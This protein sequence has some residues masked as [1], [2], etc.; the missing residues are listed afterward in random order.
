VPLKSYALL[1]G[2]PIAHQRETTGLTPHHQVHV[3]DD[4]GVDYRVPINVRSKGTTPDVLYLVDDDFQHPVT[5]AI[6]ALGPGRHALGPGPGGPNLDFVRAN[7]FDATQMRVLP[8]NVDGPE[9]D[10]QDILEGWLDRAIADP[11]ASIHVLGEPWGPE[12]DPDEKFGFSPGNGVHDIHMNQGNDEEFVDQDGVWQDGGLLFHFPGAGRWVAIFLSF[13]SQKWHTDD[14][15][16]HAL[17][18]EVPASI[19]IVAALVNPIGPAPEQERVLLLNASP[20][21][22][23]LTGWRLADRAKQTC[24]VPAGPLATG[25]TLDVLVTPP[26]TLGNHGGAITLLDASG[27]KVSGVAYTEQQARREGWTIVF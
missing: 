4:A 7:L 9:N 19:R 21:T 2:R 3:R 15:T 17:D 27:L 12:P 11:A 26:M 13:Q 23:D 5:A 18:V 8:A 1:I 10:L 22:V 24:P 25:A 20:E 6:E 16:G 14:V